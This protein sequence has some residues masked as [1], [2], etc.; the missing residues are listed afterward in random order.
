MSLDAKTARSVST[1][2]PA[3]LARLRRGSLAVLVLVVAEYLIGMYVNLF[4]TIPRADHGHGVGSAIANG[5]A[6]LA[7]HAVIGLLL[8]L[9]ALGVLVQAIMAATPAPSPR[10]RQA[11]SRWPLP[12]RRGPASPPA[13]TPPTRWPCRSSPALDCCVTRPT[14]ICC[15]RPAGAGR[16]PPSDHLTRHGWSTTRARG[17]PG[18]GEGSVA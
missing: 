14:S 17:R 4:V 8:G 18:R 16:R 7:T 13:A 6:I 1:P 3:S 11:C 2:A 9:A 5:P 10:R 12:P 15:H